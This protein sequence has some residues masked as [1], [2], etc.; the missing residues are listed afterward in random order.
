MRARRSTLVTLAIG[1]VCALQLLVVAGKILAA[2]WPHRTG[3]EVLLK[4]QPVDPRSLLR[5]NYARLDYEIGRL[6]WQLLDDQD[7][8]WL[9]KHQTVYVSLQREGE[10]HE[11]TR[12]SLERP[13]QGLYI[14]GQ[15]VWGVSREDSLA[16]SYGIAAYFASPERALAIERQLRDRDRSTLARVHLGRSGK[17]ALDGLIQ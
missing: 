12:V 10:H 17:A 11:A 5:G 2:E 6:P 4:V 9:R 13:D 15:T 1:A 8:R 16:I 3:Q 7:L 14:R